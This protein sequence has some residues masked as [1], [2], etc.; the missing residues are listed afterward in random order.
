MREI[1]D[2]FGAGRFPSLN[3]FLPVLV[4]VVVSAIGLGMSFS[5][6]RTSEV[7]RSTKFEIVAGDAVDRIVS[8]FYQHM[9]LLEAT[10]AFFEA[11]DGMVDREA[12]RT[13]VEGLDTEGRYDG[14]Q[15]IGFARMV[16]TGNEAK[17]EDMIA[18]FY[19][20]DIAIWPE[21]DQ[22]YRAAIVLLEPEDERNSAAIGFDMY[23]EP[24][25]RE[26]MADAFATDT[27]RASGPVELVQEI[28]TQK[29]AGFLL[30]LPF[31]VDD[32]PNVAD[33]NLPLSG[34]IY[35]P[36]RAGDLYSA[37]M[38]DQPS[39]PVA[40]EAYDKDA[41]ET[42]LFKS[43]TF[44]AAL[45]RS[46]LEVT[47]E[48]DIA[49]RTWVLEMTPSAAFEKAEFD[50]TP[51]VVGSVAL[52]L[53]VALALAAQWQIK[54]LAAAREV[55][56]VTQK[57]L[58]E[59]ELMLQEMKHR[60]KNSIARVLAIARQTAY[61]AESLDQFM[62]SYAAR[63]QAMSTAQDVLT[64]SRWQ[65]ADLKELLSKELEQVFG[66]AD[67]HYDVSGPAA[68]LDEK[69][70]QAF[71]LTFHELATNALKYGGMSNGDGSLEVTWSYEGAGAA[72]KLRLLWQERGSGPVSKPERKGFGTRLIDA[73]IIGE[74][75]GTIERH[76]REDG[77]TVE[78]AFP[79]PAESTGR[80][81]RW[82]RR[83]ARKDAAT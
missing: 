70:T 67:A 31:K 48:V 14:I 39:M 73:N 40:I 25:R 80:R 37:V 32:G 13:Y 50:I 51:F 30:Y 4:F 34:F 27:P 11:T 38:G 69:A 36:F 75:Q 76:Y 65:R 53:A 23:S 74:L 43:S 21:T 7:E 24:V 72:R 8:R 56:R 52:L 42:P 26:A 63:L 58:Q 59:R 46:A 6:Y 3:R 61:H 22:D 15:G 12:F 2:R 47:R 45:E 20:D 81:S 54:A 28:T 60:I 5:I 79:N 49:G 68:E 44:D 66:D 71:S 33:G 77:L 62:E 29:Q 41:P 9:S 10:K 64:R 16:Y 57:S 1:F 55:Q 35:A 17:A 18:R 19:G 78:I 83:R 82:R